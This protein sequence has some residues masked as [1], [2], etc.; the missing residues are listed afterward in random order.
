MGGGRRGKG[1]GFIL[2]QV[3]RKIMDGSDV[4]IPGFDRLAKDEG[5]A[6]VLELALDDMQSSHGIKR[7]LR[8]FRGVVYSNIKQLLC[9]CGNRIGF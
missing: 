4:S 5:Y 6:A 3:L 7:F 8:K 9:G 1:S 2:R